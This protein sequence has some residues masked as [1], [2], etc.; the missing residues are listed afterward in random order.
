MVVE[1]SAGMSAVSVS[2]RTLFKSD[3]GK[4]EVPIVTASLLQFMFVA[5]KV[6]K[7][8]YEPGS[9]SR[10]QPATPILRSP[11]HGKESMDRNMQA[12]IFRL[13]LRSVQTRV[14]HIAHLLARKINVIAG[15]MCLA[16]QQ[17]F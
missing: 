15:D 14:K 5:T 11:K 12:R 13:E 6:S 9:C 10:S 17:S 8:I 2:L 4:S 3:A 16:I 7:Q 1:F